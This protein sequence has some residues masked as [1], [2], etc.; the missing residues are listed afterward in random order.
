MDAL[1]LGVFVLYMCAILAIGFWAGRRSKRTSEDYFVAG[2]R[3][4][5]VVLFFTM[6]ATNFSAFTFFG[7]AGASYRIGFAYYGIMAFGTAFMALSFYY[8]G[9]KVWKIGKEKGFITPPELIGD[10]FGSDSLRM[11]FMAVMFVFTLPYLAVQTVG[12]GIALNSLSDGMISYEAGAVMVSMVITV[13]VMFGGMRGDAWT[14]VLQGMIMFV[15]LLAGLGIVS[16]AM[17]GFGGASSEIS[18]RFPDLMGRPGG[19]GFFTVQIW[20]SYMLLWTFADPMFPQ[21]WTRFYAAKSEKALKTSMVLYPIA[22]AVLFMAPVLLGAWGNLEFAGLK[23]PAADSILP[24]LVALHSPEW[25]SGLILAGAFAA[26]MSTA[27]S[28]L[29]V[30]SSMLTRDLYSRW[31]RPGASS[32]EEFMVGRA[33]VV[34]LAMLGLGIALFRVESIFDILTKTTFTGLAILFPTT[35]AAL[36]WKRATKWGCL[37]SIIGGEALYA[38]FYFEWIPKEWAFGFLPVIPVMVVATILLIAISFITSKKDPI[39]DRS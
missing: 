39:H 31:I 10:R 12:G 15:S 23:G 3:I 36:Y 35:I 37:A 4:G 19:G 34:V 13:Y 28:Q 8:I 33:L 7:F 38:L 16:A 17:G 6:A 5:P 22:T 21:L 20:I 2:R 27:D 1:A 25:I 24:D 14:D 18:D 26:L 11:V 29:L 30:L 32:K 9:R